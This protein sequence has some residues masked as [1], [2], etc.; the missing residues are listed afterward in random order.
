MFL[1]WQ[2][3]KIKNMLSQDTLHDI[4]YQLIHILKILSNFYFT[5]NQPCLSFLN[6]TSQ[7]TELNE[8][9]ISPVKVIIKPSVYSSISLYN[10]EKNLWG[11]FHYNN[12]DN[13]KN[14]FFPNSK[15]RSIL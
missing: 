10:K 11:R 14:I 1:H 12:K 6:F 5:H 2:V 15:F 3:K 9:F 8:N 13:I 4:I 7:V